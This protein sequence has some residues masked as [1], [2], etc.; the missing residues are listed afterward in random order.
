MNPTAYRITYFFKEAIKN[1]RFSPMLTAISIFTMAG[2]LILVGFFGG[3]MLATDDLLEGVAEDLRV[4]AYLNPEI[5]DAEIES[6]SK[7][8]LARDGVEEVTYISEEADRQRAKELLPADILEGLDPGD[9]PAAPT[10]E[11]ALEKKR[12]LNHEVDELA[13]WL[14]DLE[15][16]H[17][18][19]EIEFGIERIRLG[20]AVVDTFEVLAWVLSIV[21]LIAAIFF[22]FSTIKMAVYARSDEIAILRLVGATSQFIRIPFFIEGVFQGLAGSIIAYIAVLYGH[23]RLNT[24]IQTQHLLDVEL[25]LAPGLLVGWLFLGGILLG[26]LGSYLAVGRYLKV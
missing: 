14:K 23:S 7:L 15:G 19:A 8:I 11:I 1:V 20:M 26:F 18:V 9:L 4:T 13:H 17:R 10:L 16:I 12:R 3:L 2:A 24:Y 5:S 25:N 22:V 6:L 21:L